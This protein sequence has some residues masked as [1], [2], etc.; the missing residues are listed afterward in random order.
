MDFNE[1]FYLFFVDIKCQNA[2]E[3]YNECPKA[4]EANCRLLTPQDRK[5]K[6]S[7]FE[8]GVIK[9]NYKQKCRLQPVCSCKAGYVCENERFD[10]KCVKEFDCFKNKQL[11]VPVS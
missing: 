8:E 4:P 9:R 7:F 3:F 1:F 10:A 5:K 11:M 2:N 6:V